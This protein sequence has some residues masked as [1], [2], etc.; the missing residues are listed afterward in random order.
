MTRRVEKYNEIEDALSNSA[1]A[2]SALCLHLKQSFTGKDMS[3]PLYIGGI[4]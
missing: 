4:R 3:Y 1:L 2:E